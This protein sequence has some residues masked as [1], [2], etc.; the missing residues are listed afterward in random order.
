MGSTNSEGLQPRR[1]YNFDGTVLDA[2]FGE[3]ADRRGFF[4]QVNERWPSTRQI[5]PE[6]EAFTS[7]VYSGRSTYLCEHETSAVIRVDLANGEAYVR[8]AAVTAEDA[9]AAIKW[10]REIQPE[11]ELPEEA[12]RVTFWSYGPHGPQSVSRE[13]DAATWEE[14]E[15]NYGGYVHDSL[16]RMMGSE[17]RPSRGG[18]LILWAG[19]AGTGK[20]H[21]LRA[22]A[23]EWRDWCSIH[24]IVDPEQ[25]FG[26]HADY[27]TH[28]LLD[29]GDNITSSED[30]VVKE[31]QWRLL[32]LEDSGELMRADAAEVAGKAL[33]RLLNTVDG[34]IGQGLRIMVLVTTNEEVGKLH[35]AIAR[36]GRCAVEIKFDHMPPE[37]ATRWREDHGLPIEDVSSTPTIAELYAEME[38]FE[39]A[40]S[41]QPVGFSS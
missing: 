36:P 20:T 25:F 27:L 11:S 12:V 22:L 30:G 8:A 38:G 40:R 14:M 16:E 21:A 24:Y 39:G 34:L 5:A 31:P 26:N 13:L 17:F 33:S 29:S 41:K 18:Q 4:H 23:R 6:A 15:C 35:P 7:V 2:E 28:V 3:E 1:I 9:R 10:I 19:D 37:A 32:V